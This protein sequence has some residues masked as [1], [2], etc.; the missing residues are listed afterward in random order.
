MLA[1]ILRSPYAT[2]TTI[3]IIETF[4]KTRELSRMVTVLSQTKEKNE[5]KSLMQKSGEIIAEL[6]DN[7]L[8]ISGTETS[9]EIDLSVMKFKHIVKK[10]VKSD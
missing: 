9:F 10:T 6:L 7:D 4:T 3:A 5:Q 2:A 8:S 1:T